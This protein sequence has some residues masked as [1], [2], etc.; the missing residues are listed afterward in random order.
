[1]KIERIYTN[2]NFR[3][4]TLSKTMK[5]EDALLMFRNPNASVK[6]EQNKEFARKADSV[7]T[8]PIVSLGYKLYRTFSFI[9]KDSRE[10]KAENKQLNAI[11]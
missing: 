6:F 10:I 9:N 2:I 3:E 4:N 11:A 1:M 5:S 8:H 7:D